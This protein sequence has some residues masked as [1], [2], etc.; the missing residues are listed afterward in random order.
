LNNKKWQRKDKLISI[1]MIF[2][3]INIALLFGIPNI[4]TAHGA[5]DDTLNVDSIIG[6]I[7]R[8]PTSAES[9]D[10]RANQ[11]SMLLICPNEND[12]IAAAQDY[13]DWKTFMGIPTAV[14]S[15]YSLYPGI[16]TP[17]RIRNAIISY[18]NK[19]PIEYVLLLGDTQLIPIRYV[20]NPDSIDLKTSEALGSSTMKPTDFYYAELTGN[21][22]TDNDTLWGEDS[23][24]N[25]AANA[26]ELD[27]I[28]EVALGRFPVD[29]IQE[30]YNMMNKTIN[31]E[32]ALNSG[33]WMNRYLAVSGISDYPYGDDVNGEDEAVLNDYI[34]ENYAA[35][36][37][38]ITH[39]Y[40][41]TSYF[42][43]TNPNITQ[44]LYT[45]GMRAHINFGVS[46]AVYAGHGSPNYFATQTISSA[47]HRNEMPLLTNKNTPTFLFADA[48][49]TNSYDYDSLGED[50]VKLNDTGGIG[51]VGSMRIS[52]Y[53]PNDTNLAWLNRGVTK[54]F[55]EELF[56][57]GNYRQG[58]ALYD[59]KKAYVNSA[60]FQSRPID[61]KYIET[62]RKILLSYMLLGDPS[63]DLYT[64]NTQS[65]KP[66]LQNSVYYEGSGIPLNIKDVNGRSIPY[67][68]VTLSSSDNKYH[69]FVADEFGNVQI[70]IPFGIR[71]YNFSVFGHNMKYSSG[72]FTVQA[73]IQAPDFIDEPKITPENPSV[74]DSIQIQVKMQDAA[75]GICDSYFLLSPD[76]FSTF[77]VYNLNCTSTTTYN[78]N[79]PQLDYNSYEYAVVTFDY[80]NNSNS[81][82]SSDLKSFSVP[83]PI[84]WY[85][86]IGVNLSVGVLIIAGMLIL[87][88]SLRKSFNN[89]SEIFNW[90]EFEDPVMKIKEKKFDEF[91]AKEYR[92]SQIQ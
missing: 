18:Y 13:A 9:L 19:Y 56:D 48:C 86:L 34:I 11:Y 5:I 40:E 84:Q 6:K 32:K 72:S 89:S 87:S 63:V 67:A 59:S 3:T 62:E 16:D 57:N 31:Y 82:F 14:V 4:A 80:A 38:N 54:L 46:I 64:N 88:L 41:S 53:Y 37:M 7:P 26:P 10:W 68:V 92:N 79:L 2:F 21:W 28:P 69:S 74:D 1:A 24:Y 61:F 39:L 47:L 55:F 52:W 76:H 71:A 23:K 60:W 73:D 33:D 27:Y 8:S 44:K 20:Y 66:I 91:A 45:Y 75:S 70:H 83:V 15:N 25:S 77:D 78:A 12:F 51:F 29:N 30:L 81:T 65:F 17:E 58:K 35:S 49:S 36:Q 85:V 22:N 42:T 90:Q 50:F 43:P